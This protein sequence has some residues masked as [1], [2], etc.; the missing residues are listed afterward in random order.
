MR[1]ICDC[2]MHILD[3]RYPLWSGAALDPP[4]AS[5]GDYTTV[6]EKIG[7]ARCV[8][9]G[10]SIYGADN[11][12]TRDAIA[13]LGI[14]ARGTAILTSAS[15]RADIAA[16]D[17]AGFVAVRFN[18]I[19]GGPWTIEDIAPIARRVA[20]FRWHVQVYGRPRQIT[21][22]AGILQSL[23]TQVV[24][25]HVGRIRDPKGEDAAAFSTI[26]KLAERGKTWVKLSA[27]YL[28]PDIK[29]ERSARFAA[30]VAA[31]VEAMPERLVWGSDWPHATETRNPP[32]TFALFSQFCSFVRDQRILDRILVENPKQLYRFD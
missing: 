10:P 1:D 5:I 23:P 31:F 25:E 6:R 30:T 24:I 16:L 4:D 27:P 20:D 7:I 29:G 26:I 17:G 15:T 2:H 9:A 28:E 18:C 12:C 22:M 21:D 14:P 11:S 13:N 3:H 32:D 8:V 19:Q